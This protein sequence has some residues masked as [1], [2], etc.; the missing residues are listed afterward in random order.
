[1]EILNQN[2]TFSLGTVLSV[3]AILILGN[4]FLTLLSKYFIYDK[5]IWKHELFILEEQKKDF[6]NIIEEKV[7]EQVKKY[8]LE[9]KIHKMNDIFQAIEELR[10][11]TPNYFIETNYYKEVNPN[12]LDLDK[13]EFDD[14]VKH[15]VGLLQY[16]RNRSYEDYL[17][18]NKLL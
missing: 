5:K 12:L 16:H 17:K 8:R 18:E 11:K 15:I 4:L 9:A 1:M 10:R 14:M 7:K 3:S 6:N 13:D 2:I